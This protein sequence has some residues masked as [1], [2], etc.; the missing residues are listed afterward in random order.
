MEKEGLAGVCGWM[1]G[2]APFRKP[3]LA[4]W[5]GDWRGLACLL[6]LPA[7]L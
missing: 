1:A 2:R 6:S 7:V 5:N 4:L 3:R